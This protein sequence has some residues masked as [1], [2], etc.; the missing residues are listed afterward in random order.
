MKGSVVCADAGRPKRALTNVLLSAVT[1][2]QEMKDSIVDS[3]NH[4]RRQ[5][6]SS[7]MR[8]MSW[9]DDL[10]AFALTHVR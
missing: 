8:L 4:Y 1:F 6:N 7:D 10:A 9:D 3:H 5:S 2:T